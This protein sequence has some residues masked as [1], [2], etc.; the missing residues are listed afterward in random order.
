MAIVGACTNP[1]PE[2]P[3]E[4]PDPSLEIKSV[5]IS[6][7]AGTY[8]IPFELSNP[9]S[10]KELT[11]ETDAD[12][13]SR[14]KVKDTSIDF[15]VPNN[16]SQKRR[17]VVKVTYGD[18]VK[19]IAVDQNAFEFKSLSL[20]TTEIT[21]KGAKIS[22]TPGDYKGNYFFEIFGKSAVNQYLALDEHKPGEFEY[23]E[24]LYQ[25]DLAY[26]KE[27]AH[28]HGMTLS[29]HLQGLP[30][31]YKITETGESTEMSYS[32]LKLGGEYY[33]VA[34]G[35]DLEG[36]RTTPIS[37]YLFATAEGTKSDL[38]FTASVANVKQTSARITITPS[39][40]TE[41][42]YWTYVNETEHTL[43]TPDI[44]MDNMVQNILDAVAAGYK[45]SQFLSSGQTSE[46]AKE[47]SMGT[48]YYIYAWGM[49]S[50]GT[51]TTEPFE[52]TSFKT[53]EN[54]V[55]DDCTFNIKTLEIEDM[56]IKIRVEPSNPST[57]YYVAFIDEKRCVG[58]NDYQMIQRIVN[59]E[60]GRLEQK[61]Y[62]DT[63]TDWTNLPGVYSGTQDIWGRRD[64]EWRFD[65]EHSYRIYAFGVDA[66]GNVTT[67]IARIDATT[68]KAKPS[69]NTFEV[70]LVDKRW[71][72]ASFDI[73]PSNNE[74]YYLAYLVPSDA[75][76]TYRYNDGTLM[77]REIMDEIRDVYEDEISM[78]VFKG[79][80]N[81]FTHWMSNKEYTLLL[82]GYAGS[83]TTPMY[84]FH[85]KSPEIPFGESDVDIKYTYEFFRGD[86]LIALDPVVW[87]GCEGDCIMKVNITPVGNPANY[88]FGIW[89][90]KENFKESGGIDHLMSLIVNPTATG[91]NIINK[92][93]GI[94][95]PWW[96]GSHSAP[97]ISDE[98]EQM[99]HMP[100][101]ITA[102]AEDAEGNYGQL[103][104][105]LFINVNK[106]KDQV[107]GLHEFGYSTAYN[108]WSSPSA[109]AAANSVV[110]KLS[111]PMTNNN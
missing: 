90:P 80:H 39:N 22:I 32:G 23:G 87:A 36:K 35:M 64:L 81:Y 57:N 60:N 93:F 20:K 18:I 106:P 70:E 104:Y 25:S 29:E 98:G 96:N 55:T 27:Q 40:N 66:S 79:K 30:S 62:G 97:F 5:E 88:Y 52:L 82:F 47:L 37:L 83:N 6:G 43:Y 21:A 54:E 84:E 24:A 49:A 99:S 105:E 71:N 28:S 8:S 65:P 74:D 67:K 38:T 68:D 72:Y 13:I 4:I 101:S 12:W 3:E 46:E 107:T 92:T 89:P 51:P 33:I 103:H 16:F 73:T 75:L 48:T 109:A 58:Y 14:I 69:N 56:D 31:M 102:Y 11:A 45:M 10:G 15:N 77:E 44:I 41:T 86:D 78:Y 94:L 85:F 63:V 2:E 1:T 34:Y 110:I 7:E 50:D 17:A 100:W 53:L 76:D 26:L 91:D 61:Y 42:Y 108:W 9:V 19:N 59:M 111:E 95:K